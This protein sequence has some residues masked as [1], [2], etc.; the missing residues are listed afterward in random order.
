MVIHTNFLPS[1]QVWCSSSQQRA[2]LL[3]RSLHSL[4]L[5]CSPLAPVQEI[6]FRFGD[7]ELNHLLESGLCDY[8]SCFEQVT[9]PSAVAQHCNLGIPRF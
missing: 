4:I 6:L 3:S 2:L 1:E 5:S 9:I 7:Q 8:S